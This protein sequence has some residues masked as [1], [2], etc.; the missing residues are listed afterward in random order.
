MFYLLTEL[1]ERENGLDLPLN[2]L[3]YILELKQEACFSILLHFIL[4]INSHS[5]FVPTL[6]TP[7]TCTN[8]C[9]K[10]LAYYYE[11]TDFLIY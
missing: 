3:I 2:P 6:Q 11:K 10:I 7:D 4:R 5:G 8:I 9:Y 1:R